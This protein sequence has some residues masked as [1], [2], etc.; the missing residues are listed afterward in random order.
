MMWNYNVKL[1]N[2]CIMGNFRKLL[3]WLKAKELAVRIY[4]L[5]KIH[6][7]SKD[8]GL[9]DQIQRAAVSIPANIAE[10][11]ELGTDRQSIKYFFIAKG[12]SAE[13][14]TLLMIANEIGYIENELTKE[15]V[16]ECNVIS[17]MLW[18]IIKSRSGS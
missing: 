16:N 13:L 17:I 3:V 15:L 7:L 14:Q 4:K 11:D 5:G 9:K 18:K 2:R 10:G 8:Y 1:L 12:S 6:T